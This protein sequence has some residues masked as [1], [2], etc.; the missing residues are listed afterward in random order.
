[1]IS[2]PQRVALQV[3]I[4]RSSPARAGPHRSDREVLVSTVPRPQR[5]SEV[6]GRTDQVHGG[7]VI[8]GAPVAPAK[9]AGNRAMDDGLTAEEAGEVVARL[10]FYARW[11]KNAFSAAPVVRE[12]VEARPR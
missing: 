6:M 2:V 11:P 10:A 3:E 7:H 9:F 4:G 1:L 5:L 12:V 8:T